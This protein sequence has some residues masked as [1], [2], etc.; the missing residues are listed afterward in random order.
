MGR[1][2]ELAIGVLNGTVG[3]Y[4]ARTGN[5]LATEMPIIHDGAPL[6]L[7]AASLA[8]IRCTTPWCRSR[9]PTCGS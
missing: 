9:T 3:D 2:L 1:N 6:A 8:R 7:N 5:G 4:L